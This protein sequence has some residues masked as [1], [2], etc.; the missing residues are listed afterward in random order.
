MISNTQC[1]TLRS[2]FQIPHKKVR[3]LPILTSYHGVISEL[4]N[5]SRKQSIKSPL[6][7]SGAKKPQA[8]IKPDVFNID[9]TLLPFKGRYT[10][11]ESKNQNANKPMM[12]LSI[13]V[14]EHTLQFV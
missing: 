7:T 3:G 5:L 9:K 2:G 1:L 11:K 4:T 13:T 12:E 6:G 10:I 8:G 14:R